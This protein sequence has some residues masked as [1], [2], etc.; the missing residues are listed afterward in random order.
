LRPIGARNVRH[1]EILLRRRR[2]GNP[3]RATFHTVW[4]DFEQIVRR[5]HDPEAPA[6]TSFGFKLSASGPWRQN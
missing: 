4:Y 1:A 6:I 3:V 5:G 2:K